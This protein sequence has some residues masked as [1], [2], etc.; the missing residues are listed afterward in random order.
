MTDRRSF[1][2]GAAGAAGALALGGCRSVFDEMSFYGP[3]VRDRLWMWGHHADCAKRAAACLHDAKREAAFKWPGKTV[4]QAEGCRLM[5]I[6]NDCVIRWCNLPK[7]PWG[8]Y[9]DQFKD[10]KRISFGI[11]DG[12]RETTDEKM[13]IAFEELQPRMPNLTGCFLDDYFLSKKKDYVPDVR[14]LGKISEAVHA[15]GLRLSVVAYAD[16]VGIRPEFKPHFD[17]VDE[18]SF[19]FWKG[20]NIPTMADQIRRC[21][22]AIGPDKDMLLGLYMWDFTTAAPVPAD[23]MRQQLAFAERFLVDR[24]ISGL[25]FHP[26]FAAALDVPS[27][28]LAKE[29]IAGHG[30]R[31]LH[32]LSLDGTSH[33]RF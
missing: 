10:L 9:F 22:E 1:I 13:R 27:V 32:D 17:L 11:H 19:W 8:D 2:T 24:T 29:W 4:E 20:S 15:H 26:T 5:G 23:L 31:T 3:T 30:E 21:R 28:N 18:V 12:G 25:I 7:Y 14:K 16:Q 33:R 6:P